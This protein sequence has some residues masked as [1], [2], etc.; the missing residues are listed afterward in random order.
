LV[1]CLSDAETKAQ[2][3]LRVAV[4]KPI[5]KSLYALEGDHA[6]IFIAFDLVDLARKKLALASGNANL[7]FLNESERLKLQQ[8]YSTEDAMKRALRNV[9][10]PANSYFSDQLLKHATSWYAI[11]QVA[12]FCPWNADEAKMLAAIKFFQVRYWLTEEDSRHCRDEVKPFLIAARG[13]FCLCTV[14]SYSLGERMPTNEQL[15]RM[16]GSKPEFIVW[17]WWESHK[18]RLPNLHSLFR[19]VALLQ[20]TSAGAERVFSLFR[21]MEIS[22]SAS[23][24]TLD[25]QGCAYYNER[26]GK[27]H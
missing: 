19:D 4:G 15:L 11:E 25:I 26:T 21:H 23:E 10:V 7:A 6:M 16:D 12:C 27:Q 5:A 3:I 24:E 20:P 17:D 8:I 18:I 9:A 14:S 13:T 1:A 22:S 2:L